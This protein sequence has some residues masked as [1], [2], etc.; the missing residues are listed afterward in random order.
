M[1]ICMKITTECM[2]LAAQISKRPRSTT[3]EIVDS[4]WDQWEHKEEVRDG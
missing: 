3:K 2:Y 1:I 4:L